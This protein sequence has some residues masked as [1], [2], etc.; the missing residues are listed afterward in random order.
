MPE[1]GKCHYALAQ[2]RLTRFASLHHL[3]QHPSRQS[4]RAQKKINSIS[5]GTVDVKSEKLKRASHIGPLD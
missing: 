3:I 1:T 4:L 5:A 2:N